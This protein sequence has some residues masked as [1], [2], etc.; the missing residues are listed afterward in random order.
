MAGISIKAQMNSGWHIYT[1]LSLAHVE[2]G[3]GAYNFNK[4]SDIVSLG[5]AP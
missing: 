3:T 2:K 4:Q 5:T 1:K